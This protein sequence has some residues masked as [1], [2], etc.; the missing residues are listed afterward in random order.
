MPREQR[1]KWQ[2][3]KKRKRKREKHDDQW[4]WSR[5]RRQEVMGGSRSPS[6][7][8]THHEKA[9]RFPSKWNERLLEPGE[10]AIF[11]FRLTLASV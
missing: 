6:H 8:P 10:Q 2:K 11:I 7:G 5:E 3:D 4:S 1:K 9:S